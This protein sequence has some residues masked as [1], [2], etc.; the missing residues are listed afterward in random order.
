M[1]EAM[2]G[3]VAM[4]EYDTNTD[5]C[6]LV[7]NFM[8]LKFTQRTV[9]VYPYEGSCEPIKGVPIVSAATAYDDEQLGKKII[10]NINEGLYYVNKLNHSLINPN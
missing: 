3:N 7:M 6:C 8:V 10:L 2:L 1:D 4:K 5:T 9:A